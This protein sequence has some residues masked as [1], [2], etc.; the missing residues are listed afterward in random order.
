MRW[1]IPD[2]QVAAH[3][4]RFRILKNRNIQHWLRSIW[5]KYTDEIIATLRQLIYWMQ[6]KSYSA[7]VAIPPLRSET[8]KATG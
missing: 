6:Q 7:A 4:K 5:R 8:Y 2:R 1:D 3:L